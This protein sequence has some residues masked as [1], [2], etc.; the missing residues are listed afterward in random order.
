MASSTCRRPMIAECIAREEVYRLLF[1]SP[2]IRKISACAL[3]RSPTSRERTCGSQANGAHPQHYRSANKAR[4]VISQ[5]RWCNSAFRTRRAGSSR[6]CRSLLG[7]R[8]PW[9]TKSQR[10]LSHLVNCTAQ[11]APLLCASAP[12]VGVSCLHEGCPGCCSLLWRGSRLHIRVIWTIGC[13]VQDSN[14]LWWRACRWGWP[15]PCCDLGRRRKL[16]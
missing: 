8:L 3:M 13:M 12:Q 9:K 10:W 14:C 11:Q 15:C 6:G 16:T 7:L 4:S 2:L 5:F 1:I